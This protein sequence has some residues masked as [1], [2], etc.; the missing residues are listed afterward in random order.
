MGNVAA[1][2]LVNY[3]FVWGGFMVLV[4][5]ASLIGTYFG[6][7]TLNLVFGWGLLAVIIAG[8]LALC[9]AVQSYDK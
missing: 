9:W 7:Q 4:G 6:R 8:V 2:F 3:L 5:T 1:R